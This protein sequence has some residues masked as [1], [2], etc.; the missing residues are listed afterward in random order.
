MVYIDDPSMKAFRKDLTGFIDGAY[1][2][3]EAGNRK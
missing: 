2:G 1:A 3:G